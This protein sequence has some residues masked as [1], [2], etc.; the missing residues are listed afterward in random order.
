MQLVDLLEIIASVGDSHTIS[1]DL[2]V[3][4]GQIR[5]TLKVRPR[6]GFSCS[7]PPASASPAARM[8][9]GA[10]GR[11][12][13]GREETTA[14][15]RNLFLGRG[16]GRGSL[17]TDGAGGAGGAGEAGGNGSAAGGVEAQAGGGSGHTAAGGA[18]AFGLAEAETQST[19]SLGRDANANANANGA[20]GGIGANGNGPGN[21]T[22]GGNGCRPTGANGIL[23][24]SGGSGGT[25]G[26]GVA[27]RAAVA[28]AGLAA[29]EES[30]RALRNVGVDHG[31]SLRL[32]GTFAPARIAEVLA[33]AQIKDS[34]AGYAVAALT[35][36]WKVRGTPIGRPR[37]SP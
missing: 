3:E 25:G 19:E 30:Y 6:K 12:V 7:G 11:E 23:G 26:A 5:G 21:G 15:R 37:D 28:D 16:G 27:G 18:L 32:A 4:D 20:G 24:G 8:T 9:R 35:K 36:N 31:Q 13:G 22:G 2:V 1:A 17:G 29:T 34:P 10:G 14:H 33:A